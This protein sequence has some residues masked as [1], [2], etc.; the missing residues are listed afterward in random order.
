MKSERKVFNL[1]FVYRLLVSGSV[2]VSLVS[3]TTLT[4]PYID[5]GKLIKTTGSGSDKTT[6]KICMQPATS[7]AT[8]LECSAAIKSQ[9]LEAMGDQVKLVSWTGIG[10]IPLTAFTIGLAANGGSVN[11]VSDFA[12][13]G[14][15]VYTLSRWLSAPERTQIYG[16]GQKAVQC[17][18]QAVQPFMLP[19]GQRDSF[20][21]KQNDLMTKHAEVVADLAAT[22]AFLAGSPASNPTVKAATTLFTDVEPALLKSASVQ[23][24]ATNLLRQYDKAPN[25][26]V[27]A[28]KNVNAA[29]NEALGSTIQSLNTLPGVL[30]GV[31]SL[32]Q[33][34]LTGFA[35]FEPARGTAD[36]INELLMLESEFWT[37]LQLLNELNGLRAGFESLLYHIAVMEAEVQRLTPE[38]PTQALSACGIDVTNIINPISVEPDVLSFKQDDTNRLS[39]LISGGN[40]T[41]VYSANADFFD[42]KQTPTFGD[43]L[44]VK[45]KGSESGTY[46]IKV[47][48][49]TGRSKAVMVNVSAAIITGVGNGN[50]GV[51]GR[52]DDQ[53]AADCALLKEG[54]IQGE[55]AVCGDINK[56][57]RLQTILKKELDIADPDNT[58]IDGN[59]GKDTRA[60]VVSFLEKYVHLDNEISALAFQAIFDFGHQLNLLSD[61]DVTALTES[62]D[63]ESNEFIKVAKYQDENN[64]SAT[65]FVGQT[66][67][68]KLCEDVELGICG[69]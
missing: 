3:C 62:L 47:K 35:S 12:L 65:G 50:V 32:Y 20:I 61:D 59:Y 69:N 9:Y 41:Y 10:L 31:G 54:L 60:A 34:S 2:L 24:K 21:E 19:A 44:S 45:W 4:S 13:G 28:V 57:A 11:K 27:T 8:A 52:V 40:G 26:L 15:G 39:V 64:L 1:S 16:L 6:E 63:G 46:V 56:T 58:F 49:S 48:D 55:E 51:S 25:E 7:I 66:T 42:I 33:E 38:V 53:P 29:V 30:S 23:Q 18:E 43:M 17:A 14:A 37:D 36:V 5:E 22:R 68:E 67:L